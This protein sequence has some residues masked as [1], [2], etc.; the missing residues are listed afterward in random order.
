MK[1]KNILN[2]VALSVLGAT[3]LITPSCDFLDVVPSEQ[4]KVN[5]A[6]E[7]YTGVLGFLYSAYAFSKNGSVGELP[8][9]SYLSDLNTSTDEILNPN[10]WVAE[11]SPGKILMNTLTS[12]NA[13]AIWKHNYNGIGQCMLFKEKLIE[14]KVEERGI[15][16][17]EELRVWRAEADALIA[18]YHLVLLKRYGPVVILEN[19]LPLTAK[20]SEFPGRRHFDYCVDW[21]CNRLEVAAKDLPATQ[22]VKSSGRMTKTICYALIAQARLLAASPLYNGKFPYKNFKNVVDNN[23]GYGTELIS[24]TYD[25]AKWVKAKEAADFAI[26]Y[27]EGEGGRALYTADDYETMLGKTAAQALT[28]LY[29]PGNVTDDFKKAVYRMRFLHYACE[30][31]GNREMIMVANSDLSTMIRYGQL[32]KNVMTATNKSIVTGYS[33]YNPTLNMVKAFY[34]AD[35][36]TIEGDENFTPEEDWYKPAGLAGTDRA[37]IINLH[38]GREPRFYAWIGF[39]GGDYG[40]NLYNGKALTLNLVDKTKQGYDRAKPRDHSSTGY[41][42]QKFLLPTYRFNL[43]DG[44][45]PSQLWPTIAVIRLAELYLIRAEACAAIGGE[46]NQAQAIADLNKIR[47]RAGVPDL[48]ADM[49]TS[50]MTLMDWVRRE[51]QIEFFSE[52]KRY[53]DLRRWAI[54]DKVLGPGMRQGLNCL[55]SENP[56]VEEFNK[57]I[58]LPYPYTWGPRLYLYPLYYKDVYANPQLVQ[59]PGY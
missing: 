40:C 4:V 54:A 37:R 6:M 57:P 23:D 24:M 44:G 53:F 2:K 58:R 42:C 7:K 22:D 56:T 28:D 29:I 59:N 8:Y 31:D 51:R 13:T 18:Y 38:V 52:G 5:D 35:G 21:I 9:G 17:P 20:P 19:R 46:E 10:T 32:P 1:I 25:P 41:H 39:D 50:D 43:A 14:C 15:V 33:G 55:A 12:Q 34:T 36:K 16:P 47:N 26:N 49:I 48:T 30:G 27:A 3:M 45:T 11:Y